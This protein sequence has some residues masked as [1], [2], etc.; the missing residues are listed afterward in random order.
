VPKIILTTKGRKRAVRESADKET[1][2]RKKRV[3]L[4]DHR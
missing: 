2:K 3:R 1:P 4:V